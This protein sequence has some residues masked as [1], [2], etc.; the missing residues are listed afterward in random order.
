MSV[1]ISLPSNEV[2]LGYNMESLEG[3]L[4]QYRKNIASFEQAIADERIRIAHYESMIARKR[5]LE[6]RV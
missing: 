4:E 3:A 6:E 2:L 5:D 1:K